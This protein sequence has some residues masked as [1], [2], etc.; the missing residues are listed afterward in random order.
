M[1]RNPIRRSGLVL[2][3]LL[4]PLSPLS[5]EDEKGLRELLRD[6]LY[7][8]E[9]TRD[10]EA[11]AKQYEALISQHDAQRAFAASALF[12]LAEVRRKQDRKEEAI[13]L[14]Q[15]FL[16]RFPEAETE[17][18]LARESLAALGG[19]PPSA[20]APV[21]DPDDDRVRYLRKIAE[22][23]PDKLQE[24][25]LKEV[26][27]GNP[28]VVE[29]LISQGVDPKTPKALGIAAETGNLAICKMLLQHGKPS[30]EE[31]G[32]ALAMAISKDRGAVLSYL[33]EQGLDP[34][35]PV[36]WGLPVFRS[37]VVA[38]P[39]MI[40]IVGD[41]AD[42]AKVLLERGANVDFMLQSEGY[43]KNTTLFGT[44]LH[45]AV[46][47]RN[48]P[49]V[50]FLLERGAKPDLPTPNAGITPL[51]LAASIVDPASEAMVKELLAR[52]TD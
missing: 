24:S 16:S 9:V 26:T 47:S 52:G 4:L 39:L 27:S 12:R 19:K 30:P 50:R 51:H 40:A 28:K 15:K 34:N 45:M 23:S 18:K 10:P 43:P 35:S 32:N 37:E 2:L 7:T 5:A 49:M 8:E 36:V 44:P 13:A 6:A 33:L 14:Y 11:A 1:T 38:S 31:A 41:K 42:A 3:S 21:T 20:D 29:F 25:F 48:L 22:T 46:W 17:A